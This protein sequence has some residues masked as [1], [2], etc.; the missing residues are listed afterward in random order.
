[1]YTAQ[2]KTAIKVHDKK[3]CKVCADAKKTLF[4]ITSHNVRNLK[5]GAITCPTLLEQICKNCGKHGH[6]VSR[7]KLI[8]PPEEFTAKKI[9]FNEPSKKSVKMGFDALMSDSEDESIVE[10][11]EEPKEEFIPIKPLLTGYASALLK[12]VT[13]KVELT[14]ILPKLPTKLAKDPRAKFSWADC[15][16]D[17]SGDEEE[18]A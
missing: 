4:I 11:P 13:I 9:K 8:Q 7:C 5:N 1:M 6:T 15:E 17:S 16:S 10:E 18:E 14:Q 12:Q 2:N 3:Y